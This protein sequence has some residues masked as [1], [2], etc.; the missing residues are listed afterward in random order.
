MQYS[1]EKT[2]FVCVEKTRFVCT[3]A[4]KMRTVLITENQKVDVATLLQTLHCCFEMP[5]GCGAKSHPFRFYMRV[6][7]HLFKQSN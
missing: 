2:R 6:V 7:F 4:G 3:L 5:Y 1:V